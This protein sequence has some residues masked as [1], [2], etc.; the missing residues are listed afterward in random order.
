MKTIIV[1]LRKSDEILLLRLSRLL[2]IKD[3]GELLLETAR[4]VHSEELK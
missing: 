1:R 2:K 3:Y 4:L